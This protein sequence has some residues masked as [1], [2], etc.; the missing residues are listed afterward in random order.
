M[1]ILDKFVL[2]YRDVWFLPTHVHVHVKCLVHD[3]IFEQKNDTV[4]RMKYSG[5]VCIRIAI[6]CILLRENMYN[7]NHFLRTILDFAI[8][9]CL[10]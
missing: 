9:G 6:A 1:H 8:L 10:K 4:K 5:S 7:F 2:N 3:E